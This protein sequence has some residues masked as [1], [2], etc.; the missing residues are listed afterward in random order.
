MKSNAAVEFVRKVDRLEAKAAK[1]KRKTR[2]SLIALA[3]I[4]AVFIAVAVFGGGIQQADPI[5]AAVIGTVVFCLVWASL[6]AHSERFASH[7]ELNQ[8]YDAYASTE[9]L[10]RLQDSLIAHLDEIEE[11]V[12]SAPAKGEVLKYNQAFRRLSVNV[13]SD[14]FVRRGGS[15][16]AAMR[17]RTVLRKAEWIVAEYRRYQESYSKRERSAA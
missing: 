5:S 10:H 17:C 8:L 11:R 16:Y 2:G 6:L 9:Q 13:C 15:R 4:V 12:F 1:A 14:S 7:A 3:I